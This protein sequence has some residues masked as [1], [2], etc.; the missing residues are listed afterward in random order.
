MRHPFHGL[1]PGARRR[2]LVL[3]TIACLLVMGV[4]SWAGRP[5]V[6]DAAPRGIVSFELAGD[7]ATAGRMLASWDASTRVLAAFGLGL[8]YVFLVLY[9]AWIALTCSLLAEALAPAA[10][11]FAAAGVALAWLQPAAAGLDAIE[12]AALLRILLD[13]GFEGAAELAWLCASVKFGLV[14]AGLVWLMTAAIVALV[15]GYVRKRSAG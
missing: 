3:L 9:A 4:L 8:D 10:P 6:T 5:L 12:N 7:P 15:R 2:G 13:G 11:R 14:G 1:S